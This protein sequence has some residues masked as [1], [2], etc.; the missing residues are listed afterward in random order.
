M[1]PTT[2]IPTTDRTFRRV[3]SAAVL[4]AMAP[5]LVGCGQGGPSPE[6]VAQHRATLMLNEEPA[7][8]LAVVEVRELLLGPS[9]GDHEH[10]HADEHADDHDHEAESADHDHADDH[11]HAADHDHAADLAD[12]ADDERHESVE[13]HAGHADDHVHAADDHDHDAEHEH[14]HD[15]AEGVAK[16]VESDKE[17]DVVLVGAVGGLANP[18]EHSFPDYPFA[19]GQALLFVA[20]PAAVAHA[21]EEEHHHEPGEECA[22]CAAHEEDA[23]EMLA[24]V[25]FHDKNDKILAVDARDLFDLKGGETVVVQGRAKIESGMLVVDATGLYVRR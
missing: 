5:W 13:S 9:S 2:E 14:E 12:D 16:L 17:L 24:V 6:A 10:D 20:D 3:A 19:K 15:A 1:N 18:A 21:S 22:F 23:S 7:E 25:R 11:E 8:P 4:A